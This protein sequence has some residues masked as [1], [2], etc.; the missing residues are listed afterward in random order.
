MSY[1]TLL[2]S[3]IVAKVADPPELL[4]QNILALDASGL[5]PDTPEETAVWQHVRDFAKLYQHAPDVTSIQAHLADKRDLGSLDYLEQI[6]REPT[7][8]RGD[9]QVLLERTI[10]EHRQGDLL[11]ALAKAKAIATTGLDMRDSDGKGT[12]K[13]RGVDDA[14]SVLRTAL[15][16]IERAPTGVKISGG[17]TGAE[18]AADM[19][20]EYDRAKMSPVLGNL[21]GIMQ[22]D[23]TLRGSKNKE[24]WVHAAS[25]GHLKSTF[26]ANWAYILAFFYKR[27]V[28]YFS[29]EMTYEQVRRQLAAMHSYSARF[30]D[31]R[32]RLGLQPTETA[33]AGLDYEKIRDGKLS[34]AEENFYLNHVLPDMEDPSNNFGRIHIQVAETDRKTPRIT[35]ERLGDVAERLYDQD[36][37]TMIVVDHAGLVGAE[38]R[39]SNETERRSAVYVGLKALARDFR[40]GQGMA[41]LALSQINREGYKGSIRK[42]EMGRLPRYT[43]ADLAWAAEAENSADV[44]TTT[45][46]DEGLRARQRVL[47]DCLKSRDQE[48]CQP[49]LARVMF[50]QRRILSCDEPAIVEVPAAR[51]RRA[52][53]D[54]EMIK[55][56]DGLAA[57]KP[58]PKALPN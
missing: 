21:T 42:K 1:R 20:A 58:A 8:V 4:L 41:V 52:S 14:A 32:F 51:S 2:R 37:F 45:Y 34:P 24:L 17:V 23:T 57:P 7:K 49:F 43:T 47:F 18:A 19:R 25:T 27:S 13:L 44:I 39:F 15:R 36:P 31:I 38:G 40:N 12:T 29:L 50:P 35:I 26:A 22:I 46:L 6:L 48:P 28:L 30:R 16:Q 9:Y 56:L 55:A 33:N 10:E 11:E 5:A 3:T 54:V 53:Q